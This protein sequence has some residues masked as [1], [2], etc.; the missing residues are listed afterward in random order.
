MVI[1]KPVRDAMGI[2]PGDDVYFRVEGDRVILETKTPKQLLDE[3]INAIPKHKKLKGPVDWDKLYDEMYE[4]RL[5]H[6]G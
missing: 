4:E 6:L 5:G 2:R 3:F 1:P